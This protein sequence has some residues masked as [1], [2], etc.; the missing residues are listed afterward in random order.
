MD[1]STVRKQFMPWLVW[2][3]ATVFV[4]FQ[5][6]LQAAAGLMADSWHHD[7]SLNKV[8][9][10]YLSS[11][12]F[13]TYVFMQI[14]VGIAYDRFGARKV[15]FI[16]AL[17][18]AIGS[19]GTSY[20]HSF[21]LAV[22]FRGIMGLGSAFGFIGM[23]YVTAAWFSKSWFTLLI[24]VSETLASVGVAFA[25]IIMAYIISNHGWRYLMSI[26]G[27]ISLLVSII[28]LLI[29]R[30]KI[31]FIPNPTAV[32][33]LKEAIA[34][35]LTNKK[36]WMAG[37]Y[38]FAMFSIV[39]VFV[40]LWGVP[41]YVSNDWSLHE[42]GVL[43]SFIFIGF[44]AGGPSNAWLVQKMKNRRQITTLFPLIA[45][46]LFAIVLSIPK[47]S[48]T[49]MFPL[50]FSLGYFSSSYIHVYAVVRESVP[51]AIRATALSTT[52]MILMSSAPILQPL[53]GK[54]LESGFTYKEAL[55]IHIV[56]LI[57]ASQLT[58]RFSEGESEKIES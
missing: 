9:I 36:V 11:A 38:G 20:S 28:I 43:M 15:L 19:Y 31:S 45:A 37:L 34:T 25:E 5:F 49:I 41:F 35:V 58:Y 2:G 46:G 57:L 51:I 3:T 33:P 27:S 52:N 30:D 12:F 10:G 24:G 6:F 21:Q 18:L 14:P 7:F 4:L 26:S 17:L 44:A 42:A 22:F 32:I 50:L 13:V 23:L 1:Y 39:N 47:M 48:I 53:I 54:L 55:S 16:A 8:E 40:N 29:I 56:L